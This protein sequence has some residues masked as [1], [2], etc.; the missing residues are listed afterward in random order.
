[1][2]LV[3]Q[4]HNIQTAEITQR[5]EK[6]QK[7]M[8]TLVRKN[9]DFVVETG[10]IAGITSD[11]MW[12]VLNSFAGVQ[13]SQ[14]AKLC[15][16]DVFRL[17][18][19]RLRVNSISGGTMVEGTRDEDVSCSDLMKGSL[20]LPA[21]YTRLLRCASVE[22]ASEK[23]TCKICLS[24]DNTEASP[25]ISPCKCA[26]SMKFIH[27][28]CLREALRARCSVTS[29]RGSTRYMW[30]SLVCELCLSSLPLAVEYAG[31]SHELISYSQEST[32]VLVLEELIRKK[33]DC[34]VIYYVIDLA[35][36]RHISLG[37]A[38]TND[39]CFEGVPSVCRSHAFLKYSERGLYL[40][41]NGSKFGT[42]LQNMKGVLLK[43]NETV[44]AQ[45]GRSVLKFSLKQEKTKRKSWISRLFD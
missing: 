43:E 44:V 13:M 2:H 7:L 31:K 26:G 38:D 15:A 24:D 34:K 20:T 9:R 1:M 27:L 35:E 41:D 39:I 4:N 37:R 17:G 40:H 16:G 45:L 36:K 3:R 23:E 18:K 8:C 22:V 28:N 19:V 14:A 21:Q 30:K 29:H 10:I 42:L 11:R 32:E 25:L 33:T 6:D 5:V 12:I